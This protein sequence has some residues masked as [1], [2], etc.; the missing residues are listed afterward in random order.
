[1]NLTKNELINQLVDQYGSFLSYL[2]DLTLSA[3]E[4]TNNS[5]SPGQQAKHL[6]KSIRPINRALTLPVFLLK[7]MGKSTSIRSYEELITA[8]QRKLNQGEKSSWTYLPGKAPFHK[9]ERITERIIHSV[10]GIIRK[11]DSL[12]EKDLDRISLPHPLLGKISLREMLYF[13]IYNVQHHLKL[14]KEINGQ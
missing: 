5:W 8:Y 3:Y 9:K 1:M 7:L 4:Q 11:I 13:S 6:L 10:Q 14:V 12:S 2:N